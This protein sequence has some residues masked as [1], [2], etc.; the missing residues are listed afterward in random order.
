MT[1]T[2]RCSLLCVSTLVLGPS[3]GAQPE[4]EAGRRAKPRAGTRVPPAYLTDPTPITAAAISG[5][6][7]PYTARETGSWPE[8]VAIGDVNG[9][10]R[11]DVVLTTSFYFDEENDHRLHV[12]LQDASGNLLPPVKYPLGNRP[13]SVDIGDLNGDGRNDVVVASS[14]SN[15]VGVLTQNLSGALN[16]MVP[17]ATN[18]DLRVRVGDFNQDGRLDVVSIGWGTDTASLFLQNTGGTLNAP[19]VYPVNHAGYDDLEVGDVN[20][21]GLLDVVVMSG[22][23]YAVP[24][25]G[26]LLQQPA[27]GLGGVTYYDLPGNILSQGV[28]VGDVNGDSRDDVV[29]SHGGNSPNSFIAVFHQNAAGTL[30]AAVN[31]VSRDIPEPVVAADV[32]QDGRPDVLVLHGG[33]LA[34]GTY[35][36][37][38]A[39]SLTP[40]ALD[41]VPYA[42][43]YN[44]H[45]F[46]VGDVNQDGLPDAVIADYNSG[47]VILYHRLGNELSVSMTDAP[48]PAVVG[49]NVTYTIRVTNEGA[50]PMTGV[51]LTDTL[52]DGMDFVSSVPDS[53]TCPVAS[54]TVTCHL[55]TLP[56]ASTVTVTIVGRVPAQPSMDRPYRNTAHVM[57][58]EGETDLSDNSATVTTRYQILCSYLVDGGGFENG[59]PNPYWSESSTHFGTPLCTLAVCGNGGD[60]AGPRGGSWWAWFGGVGELEAASLSQM[61]I[62]PDGVARLRFYLWNG[63]SSGNGTDHFAV[64]LDGQPVL[65]V[66]EGDPRY[67]GA[68]TPIRLDLSRFADGASHVLRFESQVTGPGVTSFSLDD[69]VI[70]SAPKTRPR[71]PLVCP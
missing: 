47:L 22:Q 12:F 34:M 8:A 14:E 7:H 36:Q 25:I 57:A 56:P 66:T 1:R 23:L 26:V 71:G 59:S 64:M 3:G 16:A 20:D 69:V 42:S 63:S 18:D 13:E 9:D 40:E 6:F 67:S 65:T 21:D 43:H 50:Q 2:L 29:I 39:G 46:A 41:P 30:D 49:S 54:N 45:G 33:F 28:A 4:E 35:L 31:L 27:G 58:N 5:L 61:V 55:G 53:R 10:G 38:A 62:L 44:P 37:S 51:T 70:E 60:T 11:P 24:N 15:T 48:D 52:P 17:Y 32:N 68:Y 19:L